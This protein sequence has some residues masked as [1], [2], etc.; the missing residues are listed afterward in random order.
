[1]STH[2]PGEGGK[3]HG[4]RLGCQI[5]GVVEKW[6]VLVWDTEPDSWH[7]GNT[8]GMRMSVLMLLCLPHKTKEET[9]PF[10]ESPQHFIADLQCNNKL[11]ISEECFILY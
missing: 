11:F 9:L 2:L 5:E 1:M 8:F 4:R 7:S 6:C 3:A 10:G